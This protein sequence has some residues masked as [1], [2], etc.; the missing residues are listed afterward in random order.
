MDMSGAGNG[1]CYRYLTKHPFEGQIR[2][3]DHYG[4][5]CFHAGNQIT[6]H[7]QLVRCYDHE[8]GSQ[9]L[10]WHYRDDQQ[11]ESVVHPG[12]CMIVHDSKTFSLQSCDAVSDNSKWEFAPTG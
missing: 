4:A 8:D 7:V 3:E 11:L 2:H 10:E 9:N 6:D 5:R 1:V 12:Q